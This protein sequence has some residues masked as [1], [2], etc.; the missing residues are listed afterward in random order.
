[1][2][3][4]NVTP[5]VNTPVEET[6]VVA[7]VNTPAEAEP[8]VAEVNNGKGYS[9]AALVLGILGIIGG[10]FPVVCY[11]TT[12]CAILGIIFG[13]KG[14]KM[15]IEAEGKASGLATAGLVL[16]IIGTAFAALGLVCNVICSAAICAAAE[17]A[18]T[19]AM[20]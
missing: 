20:M 16:G 8:V 17:G 11:F 14:R 9:I 13:V 1:M 3:N 5:E 6:P 10:W 18:S 4:Q 7:E 12:V 19:M 2:D 15:S